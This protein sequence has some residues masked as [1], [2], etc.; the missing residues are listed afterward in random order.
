MFQP[1]KI[2]LSDSSPA[3]SNVKFDVIEHSAFINRGSSGSALI[4][5]NGEVVGVNYAG[6]EREFYA[7]PAS[8]VIEFLNTYVYKSS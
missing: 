4:N 8:R 2:D 6:G 3:D 7:V 1:I 5:P